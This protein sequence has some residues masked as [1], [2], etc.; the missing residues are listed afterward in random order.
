M[1]HN[2]HNALHRCHN[3]A[4]AH[5]ATQTVTAHQSLFS[6]G[7]EGRRLLWLP[8]VGAILG[9]L[10]TAAAS[11]AILVGVTPITP[12]PQTTLILAGINGAFIL[13]LIGLIV[14]EVLRILE[15][16]QRGKA[17]SRLHVRI[18]T[19]F[20]AR[21]RHSSDHRRHLRVDHAEYRP[22]PLVRDP[23]QDDHQ[24]IAV[25]IAEAYVQENARNLQGTTLSMA[26]DLDQCAHALQS[27]PDRISRFHEPAGCRSRARPCSTHPPDGS[28]IMSGADQSRFSTCRNHRRG[29]ADRGRRQAGADRTAAAQHCRRD[30][31]AAGS[32]TDTYLY[33]IRLVDPEVIRARQIVRANT[34]E[35]RGL[36]ANRRTSQIAFALA[37]PDVDADDR[38]VGHLDR[39][40]GGRPAGAADP[41]VDRRGGRG[42]DRQSRRAVPVRARTA[43]SARSATRSTR[44]CRS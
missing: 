2:R 30:R 7:R 24:F 43:M 9:A 6:P 34:D 12:T 36:E 11:F 27:G 14:R 23:H 33:T 40:R 10:I 38:P 21:G 37:L 25:D 32:S 39:H 35:Y 8:G 22:R 26:Y 44:C 1:L 18:V 42:G 17:A 41:P 15:A 16:R 20:R 19:M 4:V 29:G 28:F 31:E 3:N 5:M 13:I